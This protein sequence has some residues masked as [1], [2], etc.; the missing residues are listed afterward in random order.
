LLAAVEGTLAVAVVMVCHLAVGRR[1]AI[2]AM[3][4]LRGTAA[5]IYYAGN[6]FLSER[7]RQ[8]V[9]GTYLGEDVAAAATMM[10]DDLLANRPDPRTD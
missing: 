10:S 2:E 4:G 1:A 9:P 7:A 3:D 5:R 6:G 8:N